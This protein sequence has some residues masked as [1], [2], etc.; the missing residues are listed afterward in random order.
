MTDNASYALSPLE[1]T[2]A[3]RATFV[4]EALK[5]ERWSIRAAALAIGTNHT[6]L[7]SR[8]KG[9]TAFFAEDIESLASILKRDP[10]TFYGEY[11]RAGQDDSNPGTLVP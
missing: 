1:A 8:L 6:S 5:S 9:E 2:R 7:G 10:V 4:H 11:L 3:A